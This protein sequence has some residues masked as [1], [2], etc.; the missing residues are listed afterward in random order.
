MYMWCI[1]SL[2][3][4]I[5]LY[6]ILKD[7]KQI[8]PPFIILIESEPLFRSVCESIKVFLFVSLCCVLSTDH[9]FRD[10]LTKFATLTC[11]NPTTNAYENVSDQPI[12]S[13]APHIRSN[14]KRPLY[15]KTL[16]FLKFRNNKFDILNGY[17][18]FEPSLLLFIVKRNN[19]QYLMK[20]I[21]S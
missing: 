4:Y 10:T 13:T 1:L 21:G 19:F 20:K 16:Q 11:F 2:L 12:F 9:N 3:A 15:G 5:R 6:N 8:A 7:L 18:K 14:F 17:E